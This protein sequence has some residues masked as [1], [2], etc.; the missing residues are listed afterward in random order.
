VIL[1]S[2]L[3]SILHRRLHVGALG[4]QRRN[5]AFVSRRDLRVGRAVIQA[6]VAAVVA[7]A[8]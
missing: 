2:E 3:G 4:R 5:V 8:R 7:D 6:A 1:I